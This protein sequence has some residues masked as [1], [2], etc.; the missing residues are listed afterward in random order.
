M[1]KESGE[2]TI[3]CRILIRCMTLFLWLIL[4][5]CPGY[6]HAW[7]CSVTLGGPNIVKVDQTISLHASGCPEGG[8]YS[9]S[10]TPNLVPNGSSAQLT[11][12]VPSFSDYI[13]VIVT[14]TSPRGKRCFDTKWVWVCICNVTIVGSDKITVGETISLTAKSDPS[15]GTYAW[16]PLAGL[17]GNGCSA[18][19]TRQHPGD[20]LIEVDYTTHDGDACS[21]THTITV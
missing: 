5:S 4:V 16:S 18:Q 11:G 20:A 19:F 10:N 8:S 12:F 7:E 14:Y 21:D 17:V 13:R 3:D 6:L 15:G 1:E 9:W 2:E